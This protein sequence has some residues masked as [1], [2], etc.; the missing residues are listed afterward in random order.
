MTWL[1][2]TLVGRRYLSAADAEPEPDEAVA[3][4]D[5]E[6]EAEDIIL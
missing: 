3:D 6:A 5:A 2:V 1:R 4:T